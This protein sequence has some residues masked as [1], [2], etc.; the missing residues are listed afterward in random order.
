MAT[1]LEMVNRVLGRLREETVTATN[2]APY[3]ALIADF[4]RQRSAG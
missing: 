4:V 2:A 1:Y 3:G